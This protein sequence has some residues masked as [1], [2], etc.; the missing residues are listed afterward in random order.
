MDWLQKRSRIRLDV[1][2]AFSERSGIARE[3]FLEVFYDS[4]VPPPI[5]DFTAQYIADEEGLEA[6]FHEIADR[7]GLAA[8]RVRGHYHPEES[9]PQ[10]AEHLLRAG[11]YS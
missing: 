6:I 2:D 3:E 5:G 9:F 8:D 10:Y 4:E 7:T 11:A 1:A